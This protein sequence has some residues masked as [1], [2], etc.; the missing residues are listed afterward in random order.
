M[1]FQLGIDLG[2]TFSTAAVLRDGRVEVLTLGTR[3][4]AVPTVVFVRDDGVVLV[5]E[6]A[7]A[8]GVG[9]PDRVA[10]EFKRRLGDP[11]PLVL[12][13][14]PYGAER[15]AAYVL[16]HI[17]ARATERMGGRPS[18]VVITHPASYS[19]YRLDLL[20]EAAVLAGCG[21]ALLLPEPQA[22]AWHYAHDHRVERDETVAVFDFGGGTLDTAVVRAVPGGFDL[23]GDPQGLD[24]FGG[25]DIDD[26]VFEHVREQVD[27][28]FPDTDAQM[29]D[30][31]WRSAMARL[32]IEC[33]TA[34]ERLSD[35]VETVIA[36][37]TPA[38]SQQLQ[39]RRW[40]LE[41]M[42]RPRVGDAVRA[43]ER[44]TESAGL[45]MAEVSRVL[46]VG[47]TSRIP[48]VRVM[49]AEATGRPIALDA[50]PETTI[51]LGAARWQPRVA[52]PHL[53]PP[54][55]A[56]APPPIPTPP[57]PAAV[58]PTGPPTAPPPSSPTAPPPSS[59][60][61]DAPSVAS[62]LSSGL[63]SGLPSDRWAG[64]SSGTMTGVG[65][66]SR[67]SHRR[68][69]MIGGAVAVVLAVVVGV[70]A[71]T[72]SDDPSG[73]VDR[74]DPLG[75]LIEVCADLADATDGVVL[76]ATVDEA[77]TVGGE[78]APVAHQAADDVDA[79]AFA[80]PD[81]VSA[82]LL[83]STLENIGDAL[84]Q[85]VG[86]APENVGIFAGNVASGS[87]S[88]NEL[89]LG[90]GVTDG[91]IAPSLAQVPDA[92]AE[93]TVVP[94]PDTAPVTV[95][96][97]VETTVAPTVPPTVETV[98]PTVASTVPAITVGPGPIQA[99]DLAQFFVG[100]DGLA[101][102]PFDGTTLQ[103]DVVDTWQTDPTAGP[104]LSIIYGARILDAAGA[105]VGQAF[106]FVGNQPLAGTPAGNR[107]VDEFLTPPAA[108]STEGF[109]SGQFVGTLFTLQSG[110]NGWV[111]ALGNSVT[112]VFGVGDQVQPLVD[113]FVA[114]NSGRSLPGLA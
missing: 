65:A 25:I 42:V 92:S 12:G 54:P 56:A 20:R 95:A 43:L 47:G 1:T 85:L 51:A 14:A 110:T 17:V 91:C 101:L 103:T 74:T 97:T 38:G 64:S 4:S 79:I 98:A 80:A 76:P 29:D 27:D 30:P 57:P 107:I 16:E 39:L 62:G 94:A 8:R 69:L 68:L 93:T 19:T 104:A 15:L 26:A 77:N 70:V 61:S 24:R 2:T 63:P 33:R 18:S 10:R 78:L 86:A 7:E 35:D 52:A 72:G 100:P 102:A 13:G 111:A 96:P 37:A 3:S 6:A 82:D 31:A 71:F 22:A 83:A 44:A 9:E 45:T 106:I 11:T 5:G 114:A 36:V 73:P 59:P 112:L 34:K 113:G 50:D 75:R 53:P 49:L 32:R 105:E 81:D 109:T 108:V 90:L 67:S 88:A 46:L 23:L 21:D 40:Q 28:L 58:P 89:A 66:E 41:A 55:P 87:G 60:A 84:D 48:L 99:V